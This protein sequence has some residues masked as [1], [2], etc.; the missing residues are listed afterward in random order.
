MTLP[1]LLM[2]LMLMVLLLLMLLLLLLPMLCVACP[3]PRAVTPARRSSQCAT[4]PQLPA[5]P[6]LAQLG[7]EPR[8]AAAFN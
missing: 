8:G 3:A 6:R 2:R 4:E 5:T 7:N 1:M